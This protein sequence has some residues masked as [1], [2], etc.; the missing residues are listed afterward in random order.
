MFNLVPLLLVVSFTEARNDTIIHGSV[1][2][3]D[4][5]GTYSLFWSCFSTIV[6]CTWSALHLDV[7]RKHGTWCLFRRKIGWTLIA[8][9]APEYII[10]RATE[11]CFVA[12]SLLKKITRYG[13]QGWTLTHTQFACLK[14]FCTRTLDKCQ[15]DVLC[16]LI[17]FGLVVDPPLSEKELR[18][19]G[20]NDIFV[21]LLAMLQITWFSLQ[22]LARAIRHYHITALELTT[23]AFA[24]CS[25]SIYSF[26]WN[27]PQGIEYP[28]MIEVRDVSPVNDIARDA[29]PVNDN[30]ELVYENVQEERAVSESRTI[31]LEEGSRLYYDSDEIWQLKDSNLAELNFYLFACAFGAIHYLAWNAPFPT[32]AE[33]LTWRICSV[34]T[35][36]LPILA[37]SFIILSSRLAVLEIQ[38]A[39]LYMLLAVYAAGR[40]TLVVLALTAL[41]ALPADVYQTVNWNKFLPHLGT[42]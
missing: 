20:K 2:E 7:P 23:V 5:R 29:G 25:I 31:A 9:L 26:Y 4:G 35:T 30:V 22:T 8:V 40:I 3:P 38:Q 13:G 14:G 34:A 24:I 27:L 10:G 36:S 12:C 1:A 18:S 41:R 21:K 32:R 16:E 33:M 17:M 42:Q 15:P 28:I 19:R 37:A 6:V 39:V 11:N